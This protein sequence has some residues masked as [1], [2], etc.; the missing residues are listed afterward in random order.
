MWGFVGKRRR[1]AKRATR[2]FYQ[3]AG[4]FWPGLGSEYGEIRWNGGGWEVETPHAD[5]SWFVVGRAILNRHGV[6]FGLQ[7]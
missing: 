1:A 3:T 7:P 2:C 6:D 4:T 5:R